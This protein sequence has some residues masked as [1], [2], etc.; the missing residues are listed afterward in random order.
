MGSGETAI[1]F[2]S[3]HLWLGYHTVLFD[4]PI[5]ERE[6]AQCNMANG[7]TDLSGCPSAALQSW[8]YRW[9]SRCMHQQIK[10]GFSHHLS[11]SLAYQVGTL[12]WK[13]KFK[14]HPSTWHLVNKTFLKSTKLFQ[15]WG[16]EVLVT[17]LRTQPLLI[18]HNQHLLQICRIGFFFFS[19]EG[20]IRQYVKCEL[21]WETL[22]PSLHFLYD[23]NLP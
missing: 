5:T 20:V 8:F 19:F 6:Q 23:R 17:S 3:L 4:K 12:L 15:G 21:G 14:T 7:R 10:Y 11:P 22:Q 18:A 13:K 1:L 2:L 9:N 16:R